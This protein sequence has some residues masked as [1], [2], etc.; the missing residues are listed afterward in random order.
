MN[1]RLV[2]VVGAQ[3]E[4]QSAS[5]ALMA[6]LTVKGPGVSRRLWRRNNE[7]ASVALA[8]GSSIGVGVATLS[9]SGSL[10]DRQKTSMEIQPDFSKCGMLPYGK[11]LPMAT[12]QQD[13]G[14]GFLIIFGLLI[15]LIGNLAILALPFLLILA[16]L[17]YLF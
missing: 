1:R 11:G 4:A 16:L 15:F 12:K 2:S 6:D 3:A 9:M 8:G 13:S 7:R 14:G 17:K 10:S 5:H